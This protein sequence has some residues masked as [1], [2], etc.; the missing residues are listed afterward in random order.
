MTGCDVDGAAPVTLILV[1]LPA[2]AANAGCSA[3]DG[4][5]APPTTVPVT[6]T[7]PL[8]TGCDVDGAASVTMIPVSPPA[9]AAESGAT[10]FSASH[11]ILSQCHLI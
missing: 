9:G 4:C 6:T 10:R 3:Y 11:L 8:M 5:S 7:A 1:S 2:G